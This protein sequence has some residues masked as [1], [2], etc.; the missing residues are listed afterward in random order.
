MRFLRLLTK[1]LPPYAGEIVLYVLFTML[2]A[3]FSVFS[4]SAIIP[5]L[6]ILFGI[7]DVSLARETVDSGASWSDAMEVLQNNILYAIQEQT[8]LHGVSW[9]LLLIGL[10]VIV[11]AFLA[12][13]SGFMASYCRVPI[14]TGILRDVRRE[15]Y[16]RILYASSGFLSGDNR[17]DAVSRMTGDALELEWCIANALNMLVKDPVKIMVYV[18][19]LYVI[20]WRLAAVATALLAVFGVIT[21]RI[22]SPVKAIAH[23]GQAERGQILSSFDETFSNITAIKSFNAEE[24]F[25][26]R[27]SAL[28]ERNRKTFTTLHRVISLVTSTT[29]WL[30]MVILALLLWIGGGRIIAQ[31]SAAEAAQFIYFLVVFY[32]VTKP[33]KDLAETSYGIRK[34]MASVERIDK[35]LSLKADTCEPERPAHPDIDGIRTGEELISFRNVRF[36]YG[37]RVPVLDGLDLSIR[38]GERVVLVGRTGSGKSTIAALLMRF[39]DADGGTISVAGEDIRNMGTEEVRKSIGYVGQEPL[40]FN[41]SILENILL[42]DRKASKKEA[43]E[44]ARKAG[45]HDFVLSLPDGYG[46]VV[47]DRGCAL[48]GGQK[49][50]IALARAILKDAPVLILDEATSAMDPKTEAEVTGTLRTL[51]EG[52]TT[53]SITH[54]LSSKGDYDRILALEKGRAREVAD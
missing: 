48:S 50:G 30:V 47:G 20:S 49:Q 25:S 41:C 51:M 12:S 53:I 8:A 1:Y 42:G 28:N 29:D 46:T 22:G 14:R 35:I 24:S 15:M 6:R 31:G 19:T 38:K 27:F 40:L 18:G 10:F 26:S 13:A 43:E 33:T 3:M 11:T 7:S 4:F 37:D 44:A 16:G 39:Y 5:L 45:I 34:C 36:S 23:R 9:A 2:T 21:Y 52:R 32:S 17:G 54:H